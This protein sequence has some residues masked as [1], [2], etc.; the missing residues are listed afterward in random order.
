MS[1]SGTAKASRTPPGEPATRRVPVDSA[2]T[3][4]AETPSPQRRRRL[5]RPTRLIALAVGV[6]VA[7]L[8]VILTLQISTDPRGDARR[9]HLVGEAAP[10]FDLPTLDG[11]RVSLE[12]LRGKAVIINFWNSWCVPCRQEH[13]SLVRFYEHHATDGDFAMVGIVRD[14]TDSAIRRYVKEE[15]VPYTVAFDPGSQASLD[16]GTRGQPETYAISPDGIITAS[17]WGPSSVGDL[18]ALLATA[19]GQT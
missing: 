15:G 3:Q 8:A 11:R 2:T 16:F 19:R 9:S 5:L 14:D 1:T 17:R 13:P 4:Q 10:S 7:A 6:V 18:E 12:S